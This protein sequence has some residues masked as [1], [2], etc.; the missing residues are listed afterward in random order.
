MSPTSAYIHIPFCRGGKC[1]YCSFTSFPDTD[2]KDKYFSC[3]EEEINTYY[4]GKK[5][6]TLYFG[7]G[8]PSAIET[9]YLSKIYKNFNLENN[10]EKTIEV[11]PN[12]VNQTYMTELYDIG[13]NRISMGAQSFDDDILKTIGRRH[14][15]K[16]IYKAVETIKNAGFKNI[17]IDLIYG[18]PNQ[19]LEGFRHDLT[20]A[21][22][23]GIQ[24]LSLYGLKIE[25]GCYFY[26]HP[27]KNLPDGDMQ[28]DMYLLAGDITKDYGFE[29]Y[30]ISNYSLPNY[31]SR[32]NTN[33]WKANEYYGFGISAHGYIDGVRYGNAETFDDY[34][35]AP[36][37]HKQTKVLTE[38]EKLEE[39]IFLG[40]R[41]SNGINIEEINNEFN[42]NFKKKYKTVLDKYLSTEHI[43][44]TQTGYR[45][46]DDKN[47]NGFLVS[48]VILS[49]FLG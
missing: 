27:P 10:A 2:K 41:L 17:S 35:K 34:F 12:D 47:H 45:L 48:N 30:E 42:I 1:N 19:T 13:F 40:F 37:T 3:L 25:E 14:S 49:E 18:L 7:G 23:L 36:A 46:S 4:K 24:H 9:K 32:H 29:H 6:K 21:L 33:Y 5:L 22:N 39:K 8:T 20:E 28:A 38:Q 16:E 15:A 11:N 31:Y 26:K 43:E 44:E